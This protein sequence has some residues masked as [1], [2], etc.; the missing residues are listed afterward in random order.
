MMAEPPP[1]QEMFEYYR[2][3]W[4]K[5]GGAVLGAAVLIGGVV[6]FARRK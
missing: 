6:Y 2:P 1:T 4:L 5:I 3:N